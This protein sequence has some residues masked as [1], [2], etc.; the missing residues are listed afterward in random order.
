MRGFEL[1]ADRQRFFYDGLGLRLYPAQVVW[2]QRDRML[3]DDRRRAVQDALMVH[4]VVMLAGRHFLQ[5]TKLPPSQRLS[6]IWCTKCNYGST[7]AARATLVGRHPEAED[8]QVN[9][10]G[11][12]VS[13]GG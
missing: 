13:A 7:V 6:P 1:T 11:P 9:G 8:R 12:L 4:S 5:G 2:G 3:G 10:D